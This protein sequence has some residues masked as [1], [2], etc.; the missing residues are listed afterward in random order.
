[1]FVGGI[2]EVAQEVVDERLRHGTGLHV[3][4]HV[5]FGHLEAG[6]LQHGLHGND[7]RMHLAPRHRLHGHVNDVGAVFAHLEDGSHREA[8]TAMPVVLDEHVGVLL[9]DALH[10]ASQ[11]GGTSDAG[12]VLQADFGSAGGYQLVGYVGIIIHRV[13]GRISDA[14][15]GLGNH[16]CLEGILDGGDDVARFV[17]S[18]EDAGDV[19]ALR[20]LHLIHQAAH[21]GGHGIHAEGVQ[22]AVEHVGLYACLMERLGEGTHGLVGVFAIEQVHLLKGTAIGLHAGKAPHLDDERGDAHQ[23]VHPW[24]VLA[25][26]LPHVTIDEAEFDFFFHVDFGITMFLCVLACT[27]A[28]IKHSFDILSCRRQKNC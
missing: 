22:A 6:I 5:D 9:L 4:L 19:H 16:P 7:V 28:N 25:G 3:S 27:N 15:C 12:H 23:L 2:H 21:I 13:H 18:A 26:R 1:M 24:L 14:E 20:V 11:H 8:G 10:Q 17:Q